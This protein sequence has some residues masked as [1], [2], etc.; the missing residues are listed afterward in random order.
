MPLQVVC[1]SQAFTG[2]GIDHADNPFLNMFTISSLYGRTLKGL[3]LQSQT[4]MYG[5]TSAMHPTNQE[6]VAQCMQMEH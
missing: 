4:S 3:K 1:G 2:D 5:D 6:L